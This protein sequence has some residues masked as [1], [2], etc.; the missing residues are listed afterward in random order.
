MRIATYNLQNLRLRMREG[1]PVLD[2]AADQYDGQHA[3]QDALLGASVGCN[4]YE[5]A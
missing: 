1:Q 4:Q 2:G 5:G 3:C